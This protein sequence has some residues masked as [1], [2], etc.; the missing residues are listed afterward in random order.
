MYALMCD[1]IIKQLVEGS[2][3]YRLILSQNVQK[4]FT[5]RLDLI[6]NC[7]LKLLHLS[8]FC[9]VT[10]DFKPIKLKC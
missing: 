6:A 1:K 5:F 9:I 4:K 8:R 10:T 7:K 2:I 3:F